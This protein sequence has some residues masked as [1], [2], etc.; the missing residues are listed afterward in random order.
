MLSF[1]LY[2]LIFQLSIFMK[3]ELKLS[4]EVVSVDVARI[5]LHKYEKNAEMWWIIL[6]K[7]VHYLKRLMLDVWFFNSNE[8][9][10]HVTVVAVCVSPR[11]LKPWW[12]P[13]EHRCLSWKTGG[14]SVGPWRQTSDWS[15]EDLAWIYF[16]WKTSQPSLLD[17]EEQIYLQRK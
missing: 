9:K 16:S 8:V 11:V 2:N 4:H 12:S 7:P 10:L 1:L 17:Q 13:P 14:W 15:P 3:S 5:D 6:K